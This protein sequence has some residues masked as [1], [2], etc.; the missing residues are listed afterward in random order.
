MVARQA[1]ELSRPRFVQPTGHHD[2]IGTGLA[3]HRLA[4]LVERV[5]QRRVESR[6]LERRVDADRVLEIVGRDEDAVSHEKS[7]VRGAWYSLR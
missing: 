6:S 4:R 5:R 1:Q 7:V 3:P 2:A